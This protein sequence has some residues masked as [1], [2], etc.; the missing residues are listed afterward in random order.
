M[1]G[2]EGEE[3]HLYVTALFANAAAAPEGDE[4]EQG[5]DHVLLVKLVPGGVVQMVLRAL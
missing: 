4:K 5:D 2:H 3:L 1:Q